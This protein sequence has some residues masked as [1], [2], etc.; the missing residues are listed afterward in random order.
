MRVAILGVGNM[1]LKD[2]GIGIHVI[3]ALRQVPLPEEVA[4]IDGGTSPDI[5]Y[6]VDG[7]DKLVLIDAVL[8]GGRPGDVYRFTPEDV[9]PEIEITLS[10]HEI[11]LFRSLCAMGFENKPR[12][13]VI[14][15][16]EPKE[17]GWGLE[18]SPGLNGR[19]A[20]VMEVVLRE[21]E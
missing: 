7:A 18:L 5:P 12:E 20:Q 17:V 15:G 16:V 3:N 13:V 21:C 8:G 10:G 19:L 14:I 4:V 6:L 11:D 9:L 1:L 2:E